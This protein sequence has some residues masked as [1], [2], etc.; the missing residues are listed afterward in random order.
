MDEA[1]SV[2]LLKEFMEAYEALILTLTPSQQVIFRMRYQQDLST[3]A[4]AELLGYFPKNCPKS[5][6]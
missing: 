5:I 1:D 6:K 3:A 4:I 2:I